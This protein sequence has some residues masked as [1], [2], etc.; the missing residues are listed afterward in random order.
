MTDKYFNL[1]NSEVE[2]AASD[3]AYRFAESELQS[4]ARGAALLV[5][6]KKL[7]HTKWDEVLSHAKTKISSIVIGEVFD[8][9]VREV[10][11]VVGYDAINTDD[12]MI[13]SEEGRVAIRRIVRKASKDTVADL[14]VSKVTAVR[15]I[16]KEEILGIMD[17][18]G[19]L[20]EGSSL[21]VALERTDLS[22]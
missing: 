7:L 15:Q 21:T 2:R 17:K 13:S 16:L 12:S 6:E 1:I 18:A 20:P 14:L 22:R 11:R 19:M 9:A 5:A 3:V 4:I 10:R 8:S